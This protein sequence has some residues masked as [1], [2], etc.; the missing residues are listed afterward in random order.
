MIF[1]GSDLGPSGSIIYTKYVGSCYPFVAYDA[2]FERSVFHNVA[3]NTKTQ[4]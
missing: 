2:A 3:K 4:K 1:G